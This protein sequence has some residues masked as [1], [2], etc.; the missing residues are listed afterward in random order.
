[1]GL[2]AAQ[3]NCDNVTDTLENKIYP[4]NSWAHVTSKLLANSRKL[5]KKMDLWRMFNIEEE[6]ELALASPVKCRDK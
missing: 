6:T 3:D 1:M 2:C 5:Q 4:L